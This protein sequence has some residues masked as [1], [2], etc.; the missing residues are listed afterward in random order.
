M[1]RPI[2][3]R[4][5]GEPT[6]NGNEIKVQFHNGTASVNG[7]IVKQLGSKRFRCTDGTLT[8]NCILTDAVPTALLV[9]QMSIT[10]KDDAGVVTP[11]IKLSG[12]KVTTNTGE[13]IAWDFSNSIV[14]T[15][16]EMEEAGTDT[17]R[18]GADDFDGSGV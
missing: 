15:K 13:S 6:L 3:K 2:N 14:D 11:I 18:T 5:L 16:V 7:W 17:L 12:K 9:G 4:N 8:A 10:V 1:G